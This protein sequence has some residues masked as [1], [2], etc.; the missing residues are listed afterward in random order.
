MEL[1]RGIDKLEP[2]HSP[3]VVSIGN[4]DGVHLGHQHVIQTLL[5]ESDKRKAP[6]TVITFEPLAKEYFRPNSLVRLSTIEER[7]ELL[8][9]LGVDRVLCINFTAEFADYSPLGFVEEVLINGLGVKYLGIG[10]DFKFGKNRAGD[11]E[12]LQR[13]GAQRGFDVSSHDTFAVYGQRVSSGRVREALLS[14]DFAL[15]KTLLGRPYTISGV[16]VK[17][18]QRGR[19]I[20]YPTA[21]ISLPEMLMP[22][23][24][25]YAV[26]GELDGV[27][28]GG[29]A[30]V[31]KRPTVSG[32]ENRLE[33]HLFDFDRDIYS[34]TLKVRFVEKIREEQ[35]FDSFDALKTQ[36][37]LDAHRAQSI[38]A[39][40][41]TTERN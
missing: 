15:A 1:I 35:K 10:D 32:R 28:Y 29:V 39:D 16:V 3:S 19:T 31:G 20:D 13:V 24:G 17:G 33:V 6:S 36:I 4:F 41:A 8:F 14:S 40:K 37:Q 9:K 11:F 5:R 7:A 34:Q 21:N 27:E 18:E 12:F 25:V 30:N 38:L 26:Y 2:A 23:Q 22:V